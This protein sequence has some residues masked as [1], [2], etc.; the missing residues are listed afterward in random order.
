MCNES[1]PLYLALESE[2]SCF[3]V[4]VFD[5]LLLVSLFLR[6]SIVCLLVGR[7]LVLFLLDLLAC[8]LR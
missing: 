6:S 5:C 2:L 3:L 1:V 7:G 4:L 8:V